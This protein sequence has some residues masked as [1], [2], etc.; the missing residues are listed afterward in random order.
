VA[1]V[2]P[3]KGSRGS[4]PQYSATARIRRLQ[5][6]LATERDE[7]V[8]QTIRAQLAAFERPPRGMFD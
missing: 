5:E 3:V 2:H 7:R 6:R 1:L 8:L 4:R